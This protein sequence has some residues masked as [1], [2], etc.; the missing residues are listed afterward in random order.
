MSFFAPFVFCLVA[1]FAF[2][3]FGYFIHKDES[4]DVSETKM[5]TPLIIGA[6]SIF[7]I[8]LS[9]F[10]NPSGFPLIE[11]VDLGR[12]YKVAFVY[13]AGDNVNV[14]VEF[15]DEMWSSERI[16]Y[17]QFKKDAFDGVLNPNAKKLIVVQAG[18]FKKLRLE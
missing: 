1:F 7:L 10:W 4:V 15:K 8:A 13:V 2:M 6:A 12:T 5:V 16:R 17:H 9:P 3:M 18:S 14:A 11:S